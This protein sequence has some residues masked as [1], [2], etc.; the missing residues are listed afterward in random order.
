MTKRRV[1]ISADHGL[2]IV[3]FLQSDVVSTMLDAGVEVV[4]LT[5]D[6]LKEQIEERFGRPGLIVEGLR[7]DQARKYYQTVS[8]TVQWWLHFLRR[9]G[10]SKRINVEAMDSNIFQVEGE[11]TGRRKAVMPLMKLIVGLMRR[12][13]ALRQFVV[14]QQMR[15]TPDLYGDLFEKYQPELVIAS[16][17]GWRYDRYLLRQAAQLGVPTV[18]VIVGWDNSSSYTLPG[19]PMDWVNC[20]SELQKEELVLGS[21]WDP[22]RVHVGGIPSYDGYFR[23]E[24][25]MP[26]EEYFALHKLDPD[27]KLIG[28][29][30]SFITF[31]PNYQNVEAL[32]EL[33]AADELAEP[34][35]LLIRLH[36]N[37]FMDNPLFAGEREKIHELAAR[38][39][40]V[41]LVEPVPLGGELGYYS[42][43]DMPEKTSM[44]AYSDVFT[45][46][47]STMVV[48][49]A[50]HEQPIVSVCIDA[51]G[52][53]NT[54]GK[55]SLALSEIGNWPTH[56]R[57]R[58]AGAGQVAMDKAQLKDALNRY[59]ENPHADEMER[60]QFITDEV[61]YT[62]GSAGKRTAEFLLSVIGK[63]EVRQR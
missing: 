5:D 61:T 11:A 13:K 33:V 4:L 53:W 30:S 36:P 7:L 3:Y 34:C 28:Y 31:S 60:K 14:R 16:T 43:E 32:A 8:P 19:A 54:P 6:G 50:L 23:K 44:M 52:G 47:Y 17:A 41:H 24:W 9:V 29:A 26:R 46:V 27:R 37:H 25:L 18:A 58:E 51:P 2:A 63:K 40:H 38:L 15:F 39:E 35:Q 62:D 20:W 12:S 10:G 49:A 21:D 55:F 59:L 22:R 56:L 1:F 45:T 48:E 57:F 42:G